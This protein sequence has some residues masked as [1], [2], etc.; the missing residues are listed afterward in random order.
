MFAARTPAQS[1]GKL[2]IAL[3]ACLV[4]AALFRKRVVAEQAVRPNLPSAKPILPPSTRW[5]TGTP[6]RG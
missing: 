5:I 3:G 6:H 4:R 2:V 1:L